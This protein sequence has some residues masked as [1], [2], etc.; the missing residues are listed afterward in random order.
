MGM[1][2]RGLGAVCEIKNG[3]LRRVIERACELTGLD[4]PSL[5]VMSS[6]SDPYRQDTPA[7]HRDGAWLAEQLRIGFGSKRTHWRGLHY[8]LIMRKV[9][10]RKPDGKKYKN[11]EEDWNWLV[12]CAGK[13]ARW[14]G[15]VDFDRIVD[16]RNA[17]PVIHRRERE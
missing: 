16:K 5:T 7:K 3:I 9:K 15:Y 6:K 1:V 11:T 12:D 14:L 8:S 13:A 4:L 17:P 2:I 10:V